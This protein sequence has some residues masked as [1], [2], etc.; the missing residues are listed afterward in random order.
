MN[1]TGNFLNASIGALILLFLFMLFVIVLDK[2]WRRLPVD[3]PA[4]YQES[5][6]G[7]A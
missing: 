6:H 7:T 1:T 2:M 4:I 5:Q 3:H